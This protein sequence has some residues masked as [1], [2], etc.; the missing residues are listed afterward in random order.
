MITIREIKILTVGFI[1]G[2]TLALVIVNLPTSGQEVLSTFIQII[3]T[4][5]VVVLICTVLINVILQNFNK[6][7]ESPKQ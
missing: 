3:V 2:L 1:W 5:A 7:K 4:I 6:R